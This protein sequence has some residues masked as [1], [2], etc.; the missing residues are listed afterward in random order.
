MLGLSPQLAPRAR[1]HPPCAR[2]ALSWRRL[3]L[4]GSS[5]ASRRARTQD[6]L[7]LLV[8]VPRPSLSC[9]PRAYRAPPPDLHEETV[10]GSVQRTSRRLRRLWLLLRSSRH[11]WLLRE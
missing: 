10:R 9:A 5:Q 11:P 7:L 6:A 8:P 3:P 4:W 2:D 1:V